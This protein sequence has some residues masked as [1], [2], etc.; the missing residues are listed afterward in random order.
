M[1]ESIKKSKKERP[2][3]KWVSILPVS[4]WMV[5]F[6][7]IPLL[8]V[9][10]MSFMKKA[11]YGGVE[12][13]FSLTNYTQVFQ[14]EYLKIYG[15]SILLAFVTTVI[16]LVLAYP[17]ALF[18]SQKSKIVQTIFMALVVLPSVVNSLVRLFGWVT[19]LRKTGVVNNYLLQLGIIKEPIAFIYNDV[20]VIIGMVYLLIMF[21][22]LPLYNSLE[23]IDPSLIE[24]ASDLGAKKGAV[25]REVILPLTVPGIFAGCIMV[26][27]PALGIF[28]VSDILGGGTSLTMGNLIRN[29][30]M[31]AQNWPMGAAISIMLILI[32]LLALYVYEKRGGNMEDLGGR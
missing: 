23:K 10:I 25:L 32:T 22:I 14:P 8:Y 31:V 3:L 20:G 4:F 9:F 11:A 6:I 7:V 29:Q 16:C 26:F 18:V 24:V 30:F 21:M 12:L 17:F 27:I 13:G 2:L 28:F 15:S 19:L 1:E 5:V